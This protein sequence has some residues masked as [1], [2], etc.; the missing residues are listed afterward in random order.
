M[1]ISSIR[2]EYVTKVLLFFELNKFILKQ[3]VR[4]VFRETVK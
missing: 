4:R 3:N 1:N 2:Q